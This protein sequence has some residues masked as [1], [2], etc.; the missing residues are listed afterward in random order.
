M[1]ELAKISRRW[2]SPGG[3]VN[4]WLAGFEKAEHH[5]LILNSTFITTEM[6]VVTVLFIDKELFPVVRT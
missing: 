4:H 2:L 3:L 1:Q 5:C 6:A